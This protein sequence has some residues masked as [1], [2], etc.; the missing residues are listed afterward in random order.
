MKNT[1][2]TRKLFKIKGIQ[3]LSFRI[4]YINALTVYYYSFKMDFS[5]LLHWEYS[6]SLD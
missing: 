6:K 4:W 1:I 5:V 2:G 3:C